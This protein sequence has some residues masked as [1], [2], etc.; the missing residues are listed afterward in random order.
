MALWGSERG[1]LSVSGFESHCEF[2]HNLFGYSE[3]LWGGRMW[4]NKHHASGR[5]VPPPHTPNL[6]LINLLN[7]QLSYGRDFLQLL[8]TSN[9]ETG[10][11]QF[12]GRGSFKK[13][14]T[15]P[16]IFPRGHL[17]CAYTRISSNYKT[18]FFLRHHGGLINNTELWTNSL[19]IWKSLRSS[20]SEFCVQNCPVEHMTNLE[21]NAS[22][23]SNLT[24][25]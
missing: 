18:I 11:S 5:R 19:Q 15:N 24:W 13:W 12:E 16:V 20:A 14:G 6:C 23:C 3:Y 2:I 22:W 10:Y 25:L 4:F 21:R 1:K 17:L 8:C 7:H 9:L